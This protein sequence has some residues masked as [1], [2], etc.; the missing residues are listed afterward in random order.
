MVK[1]SVGGVKWLLFDTTEEGRKSGDG[2]NSSDE[3]DELGV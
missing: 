3:G 1:N 2:K